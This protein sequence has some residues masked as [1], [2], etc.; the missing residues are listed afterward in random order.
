ME[1]H[2]GKRKLLG[3][4]RTWIDSGRL[5]LPATGVWVSVR[6]Q[7]LGYKEQDRGIEQDAV[8]AL[9]C[10]IHLV[11]RTPANGMQ[12]VPFDLTTAL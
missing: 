6:R 11:R 4:L 1:H 9:V 10:A 2:N 12:N 8:M 7:L 5:I 3:E